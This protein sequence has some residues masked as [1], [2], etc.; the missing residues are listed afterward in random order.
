MAACRSPPAATGVEAPSDG[1]Q[2]TSLPDGDVRGG[3]PQLPL[4]LLLAPLPVPLPEAPAAA[5]PPSPPEPSSSPH[6]ARTS[7]AESAVARN[8][9]APIEASLVQNATRGVGWRPW[10][11][12]RD[13]FPR[14]PA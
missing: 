6:P 11:Q 8:F 5:E 14:S 1:P 10:R 3:A 4:P 9:Q 7:A 12:R 2:A 13:P